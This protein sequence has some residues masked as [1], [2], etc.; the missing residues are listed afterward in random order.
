MTLASFCAICAIAR[1]RTKTEE[2]RRIVLGMLSAILSSK[3]RIFFYADTTS[4]LGERDC[5]DA[6]VLL[7]WQ[8]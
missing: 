2:Y 6:A 8:L 4:D 1:C 3:L 7:N 5:V